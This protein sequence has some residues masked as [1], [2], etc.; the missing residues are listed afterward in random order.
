LGMVKGPNG[1]G[2]RGGGGAEG[3]LDPCLGTGVPLRV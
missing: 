1:R 2:G 3:A